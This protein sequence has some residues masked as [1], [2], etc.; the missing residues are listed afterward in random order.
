LPSD[1]LA[2]FD[3]SVTP[4]G[5]ACKSVRRTLP[6]WRRRVADPPADLPGGS[7]YFFAS[8][9][10][11]SSAMTHEHFSS[12]PPAR[13]VA[14]AIGAVLL[15]YVAALA[16]GWPQAATRQIAAAA[17]AP[18]ETHGDQAQPESVRHEPTASHAHPPYWT[19]APFVLLLGAIAVFPLWGPVAHWWES[20]LNRL[21]VALGLGLVTLLYY[22]LL[23]AHP[24]DGHWPAH[25]LVQ[26]G[27]T[28]HWASVRTVLEN[29][30]LN[31]YVPFIVLLFSLYT[32]A[33]GIRITGDLPA[34]PGT[35]AAFLA[36]GAA[37]ASLLGT[38]GA[39]MLLVRPLLETNSERK[40]VRHT[41]VFFIFMV[42]NC[43]GCLL[44]IGDPPLFLGYLKGVPFLWTLGLWQ[45]WL[46]VNG[47]LLAIY[48]LADR[49][50]F[51]PQETRR[52]IVRDE[53]QVR[54]LRIAGLSVNGP[55][56]AAVILAVALLDPSK[57]VPGTNWQPWLYL[58]EAVQL[59][60]VAASLLLAA[61]AVREA[62]RFTFAAI[63]EVAALFLGIFITMQPV[64]SILHV[65]GPQL[66]IDTPAEFFWTTGALSSV[67]DNAPTYLVFFE[68][69]ATLDGP[70]RVAGV[71]GA[72]LAAVSLGAVFLGSMTYI[73]NGPNFMVKAIAE[74]TGVKMPSFFGYMAYSVGF[75]LPVFALCVWLFL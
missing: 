42:C 37:L 10:Q 44:P 48:Y 21:K 66:G 5:L 47:T 60:L 53:T 64:L 20:N 13:P 49:L 59:G 69:A 65:Q 25:H 11:A 17:A 45:P 67:L 33:G 68:T 55:L 50:I 15:V 35:N 2:R 32:I 8:G 38:T 27:G 24:V 52:D 70:D 54:R 62:N 16:L 22:L 61:P 4:I 29:A 9:P 6:R 56:L 51:Y 12:P 73:G 1:R 40:H 43:G 31:E 46:L 63:L 36:T 71:P 34:H 72:L 23:H 3:G 75:L 14:L 7:R 19:A 39:A 41:V 18:A 28:V 26:P 58:R 74:Q 30:I 57:P